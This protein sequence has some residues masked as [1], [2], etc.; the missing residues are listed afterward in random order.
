ML[1]ALGTHELI[2]VRLRRPEDKSEIAESIAI[3][4]CS[5]GWCCR[6]YRHP[7]SRWGRRPSIVLPSW[8]VASM[9]VVPYDFTIHAR[10]NSH[11]FG[12]SSLVFLLSTYLCWRISHFCRRL[13]RTTSQMTLRRKKRPS[14]WM[15]QARTEVILKTSMGDI[16][17]ELLEEASPI[18]CKNF[19]SYAEEGFYDGTIFHRVI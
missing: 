18:A 17:L 12:G 7:L 3:G 1:E 15:I 19:V 2:K 10:R 16:T 4:F 9:G 13:A 5:F 14:P 6:P 11:S 8:A